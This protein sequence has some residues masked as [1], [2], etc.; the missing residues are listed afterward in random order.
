MATIQRRTRVIEKSNSFA[1]RELLKN[2]LATLQREVESG[3][4]STRESQASLSDLLPEANSLFSGQ[5]VQL[6]TNLSDRAKKS[7]RRKST[8][9]IPFSIHGLWPSKSLVS[10]CEDDFISDISTGQRIV[11]TREDIGVLVQNNTPPP[12][13][14]LL[15]S[16]ASLLQPP[17]PRPT[18]V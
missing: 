9:D 6:R 2:E 18:S 11:I 3:E 15:C 10:D 14:L 13:P 8:S 16:P 17:N 7:Y 12:S 5:H 1:G 4:S